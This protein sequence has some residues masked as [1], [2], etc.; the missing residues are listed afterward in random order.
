MRW[1]AGVE[2]RVHVV[3]QPLHAVGRLGDHLLAVDDQAE[4]LPHLV[5]V[6][7]LDVGA[8]REGDPRACL[9]LKERH[10]GALGHLA[11]R[12]GDHLAVVRRA[13]E[14]GIELRRRVGELDDLERVH[15]GAAVGTPV[16]LVLREHAL[17]AGKEVGDLERA[18]ADGAGRALGVIAGRDDPAA[19]CGER[20]RED[21]VRRIEDEGHGEIV[22]LLDALRGESQQL[23]RREPGVLGIHDPLE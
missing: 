20:L 16:A 6:E 8:H 14:Q 3:A 17:L 23:R 22:D 19:V 21:R 9:G 7:R 2:R 18:G 12:A 1:V 4:G 11:L 10:A 13:A 5:V 15:V